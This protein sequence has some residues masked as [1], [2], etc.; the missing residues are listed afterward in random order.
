MKDFFPGLG[1]KSGCALYTE[2]IITAKYSVSNELRD[3]AREIST[4]LQD[5]FGPSSYYVEQK[6]H[7][8]ES[9]LKVD[10]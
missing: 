10:C 6:K 1:Q 4:E 3:L 8:G 2:C 5:V 9:K 7:P